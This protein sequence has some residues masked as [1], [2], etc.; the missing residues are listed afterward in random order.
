MTDPGHLKL[1][2]G[3]IGPGEEWVPEVPGWS[4]V[5]MER[6]VG[7]VLRARAARE[8]TVG[9][10]LVTCALRPPVLRASQLSELGVS[11][12]RV[13][14]ELMAGFFTVYEENYLQTVAPGRDDA[15]RFLP[16]EHP[17]S[18][19]MAGRAPEEP[20]GDVLQRADML[21]W[22]CVLLRGWIPPL[23]D[24][25]AKPRSIFETRFLEEVLAMPAA[26]F[27]ARSAQELAR[28]CGGSERQLSRLFREYCGVSLR[29][30]QADARL[31][32]AL[33]LLRH[34]EERV[35]DV[36]RQCGFRHINAFNARF[37]DRFGLTPSEWRNRPT[38][39]VW[40]GLGAAR[41]V[42]GP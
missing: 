41:A 29:V 23:R 8:L 20:S 9:E 30:R 1:R 33:H 16:P 3:T 12:F 42:A 4:V 40:P 6:G 17:L 10:V 22:V 19:W 25:Q 7:Y 11:Y 28:Q 24:V 32:W 21:R 27:H 2:T 31:Q 18:V 35:S 15:I 37:K 14:P 26:E 13:C 36:A 34:S 39:P 5:R 38:P